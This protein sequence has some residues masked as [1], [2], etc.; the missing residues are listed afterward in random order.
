M[1]IIEFR[2]IFIDKNRIKFYILNVERDSIFE[3]VG[4]KL[5]ASISVHSF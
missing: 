2:S 5:T 3:K 1:Y 4:G